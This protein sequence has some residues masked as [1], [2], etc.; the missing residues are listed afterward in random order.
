MNYSKF[1][2]HG[3]QYTNFTDDKNKDFYG[4]SYISKINQSSEFST[5][6]IARRASAVS[7]SAISHLLSRVNSSALDYTVF[8]SRYGELPFIEKNNEDNA[9]Q[10]E[11]S[12]TSFSHSVHNTT[13]CLYS[14]ILNSQSPS[15]SLSVTKNM[16]QIGIFEATSFLNANIIANECLVIIHDSHMPDRYLGFARE[17]PAGFVLSFVVSRDENGTIDAN[18][19]TALFNFDDNFNDELRKLNDLCAQSENSYKEIQRIYSGEIAEKTGYLTE[20]YF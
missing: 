10:M 20:Y 9:Q 1:N 4:L 18:A 7:K 14:I 19:V 6:S 11:L 8:I 2:V 15:T 13:A 17:N 16:V 5:P 12:P 3:A